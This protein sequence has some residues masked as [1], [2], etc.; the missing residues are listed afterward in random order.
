MN[1]NRDSL[2][3]RG[4]ALAHLVHQQVRA[5]QSTVYFNSGGSWS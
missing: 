5:V 4:V 3:G 1:A 2:G